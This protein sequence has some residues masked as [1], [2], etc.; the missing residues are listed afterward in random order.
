MLS[1]LNKRWVLRSPIPD[2]VDKIARSLDLLPVIARLLVNRKVETVDEAQMFMKAALSTLY[3][4]FLI[5]GMELAV[6]R[7]LKAIEE[8]RRR[9]MVK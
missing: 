1:L 8:K 7:I 4:P 3:D 9:R 6:S 5:T 2:K